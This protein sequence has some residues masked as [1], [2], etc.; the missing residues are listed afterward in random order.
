MRCMVSLPNDPVK[1]HLDAWAIKKLYSLGLRRSGSDKSL[2]HVPMRKDSLVVLGFVVVCL[3][4]CNI[5]IM[6]IYIRVLNAALIVTNIGLTVSQYD[7]IHMHA[8]II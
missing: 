1:I 6:Y 8:W 3:H 4:L 5:Y 7:A 2:E